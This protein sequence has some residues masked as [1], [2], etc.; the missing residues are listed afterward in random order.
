MD[1][2]RSRLYLEDCLGRRTSDN[3]WYSFR[4][5]MNENNLMFDKRNIEL[6]AKIKNVAK[7]SRKSFPK[8]LSKYLELER[9]CDLP[10][11]ASG[12]LLLAILQRFFVPKQP[13]LKTLYRWFGTTKP[14]SRVYNSQEIQAIIFQAYAFKLKQKET[15]NA[16]I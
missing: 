7:M 4:R 12:D 2:S 11:E 16:A 6:V 1:N 3:E 5:A 15:N 13:S 8:A 10:Y 14:Y 9:R